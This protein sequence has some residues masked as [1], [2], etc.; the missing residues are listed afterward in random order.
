MVW[1]QI[2][3]MELRK[4]TLREEDVH[5]VYRR[6]F[7]R[8]VL[9]VLGSMVSLPHL[10]IKELLPHRMFGDT[11]RTLPCSSSSCTAATADSRMGGATGQAAVRPPPEQGNELMRA[12]MRV[13]A[14]MLRVKDF[15]REVERLNV[16]LQRATCLPDW[17]P[18][19]DVLHAMASKRM[20]DK[21]AAQLTVGQ[22]TVL[23]ETS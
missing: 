5:L 8:E 23:Y 7:Y 2:R 18:T 15:L 6:S 3:R 20:H 14:T 10:S 11:G 1:V 19:V 21:V 17:T 9:A 22:K 4:T 13:A 16:K 12:R